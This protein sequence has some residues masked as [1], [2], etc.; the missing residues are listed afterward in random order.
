MENK[1]SKNKRAV[2]LFILAIISLVTGWYLS[3]HPEMLA[4]TTSYLNEKQMQVLTLSGL[5]AG[6]A[7]AIS[8]LPDDTGTPIADMLMKMSGYLFV[9]MVGILMEKILLSG[10]VYLSFYFLLPTACLIFAW[11]AWRPEASLLSKRI[12]AKAAIIGIVVLTV[13]PGSVELSKWMEKTIQDPVAQTIEQ[14]EA[15]SKLAEDTLEEQE[16]D[17]NLW[18]KLVD[19]TK[20]WIGGITSGI[21]NVI[22]EAKTLISNLINSIATLLITSIIIP[23][24][25][26]VLLYMVLK[27]ILGTQMMNTVQTQAK[28]IHNKVRFPQPDEEEEEEE[29]SITEA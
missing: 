17:R 29:V 1:L 28:A 9:V 25:V 4:P 22:E 11:H 24:L 14:G 5:C 6:G 21:A 27:Q 26:Y 7:N 16:K 20:S 19:G 15:V 13:V 18:E 10:S 2:G 8:L 12:A 23:I 3:S